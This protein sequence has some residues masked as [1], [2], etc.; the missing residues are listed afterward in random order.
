MNILNYFPKHFEFTLCLLCTMY[1]T[2]AS[3]PGFS[4]LFSISCFDQRFRSKNTR[5]PDVTDPY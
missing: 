3:E 5:P 4:S 1:I 2:G